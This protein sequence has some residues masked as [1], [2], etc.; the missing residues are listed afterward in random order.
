MVFLRRLVLITA[1][2]FTAA[3]GVAGY[4]MRSHVHSEEFKKFSETKIGELLRAKV[5]IKGTHLRSFNQVSFEGIEI[6]SPPGESDYHIRVG[7]IE[8]RYSFWQILT[9]NLQ[10]PSSVVF[11]TPQLTLDGSNASYEM[12]QKLMR[13]DSG[14]ASAFRLMLDGGIISFNIPRLGQ[15]LVLNDVRGTIAPGRDAMMSVDLSGLSDGGFRSK[16]RVLGEVDPARKKHYLRI[17]ISDGSFDGKVRLPF[18]DV[19][20]ELLLEHDKISLKNMAATVHGWHAEFQ[21]SMSNLQDGPMMFLQAEI[22]KYELMTHRVAFRADFASEKLIGNVKLLGR[23]DHIF[24][25]LIRRQGAAIM[26]DQLEVDEIYRGKSRFDFASGKAV[27]DLEKEK[28]RLSVETDINEL[29]FNGRFKFDHFSLFGLDLVTEF[30]LNVRPVVLPSASSQWLFT[31]ELQTD[32]L[33]LEYTPFSDFKANFEIT[34]RLLRNIRASWGRVFRLQG[35]IMM[36]PRPVS[37][38]L[39]VKASNYDL[40]TVKEIAAKPLP[41]EL[42]GMLDGKLKIEGALQRPEIAGHFN[43][44]DGR[45]GKLTYDR[46]IIHFRGFAPYLP[47]TESRLLKGRTTLNLEGALDLSL[48]NMF[49]GVRVTTADKIALW[50][51]WEINTSALDGD[52]EIEP[53]MNL[54]PTLSLKPGFETTNSAR[55]ETEGYKSDRYVSLGTKFK[56]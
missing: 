53:N 30:A 46:G 13:P 50:K 52:L 55:G 28:Q 54:L 19:Q 32:Y 21:G 5:T 8:F 43:V 44:I 49:Y 15:R 26:I 34:P 17:L 2:L 31:G 33:I 40:R 47:L 42:G 51:G 7:K 23:E 4:V 24:R 29:N 14:Q 36:W 27:L 18:Q 6:Q 37:A 56:F 48:P 11:T 1:I 45:I 12:L 20:G 39:V 38:K 41:K 35:D 16:V 3:A 22:G 25:G 10:I 9:R